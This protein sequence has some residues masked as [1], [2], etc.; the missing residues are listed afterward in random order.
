MTNDFSPQHITSIFFSVSL[1][2]S[3]FKNPKVV[4]NPAHMERPNMKLSPKYPTSKE[5]E[6]L[7]LKEAQTKSSLRPKTASFC[8]PVALPVTAS[9]ALATHGSHAEPFTGSSSYSPTKCL[10]AQ[11]NDWGS[12]RGTYLPH[13]EGL[14]CK[15]RQDDCRLH[16]S[17]PLATRPPSPASGTWAC[18]DRPGACAGSAPPSVR[19]GRSAARPSHGPRGRWCGAGSRSAATR[20]CWGPPSRRTRTPALH[21]EWTGRG[22]P[23]GM[24]NALG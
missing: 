6:A 1:G 3:N 21:R 16:D 20:A 14:G 5:K 13:K 17:N 19:W 11:L 15:P 23:P 9:S 8:T 24:G 12:W 7:N 2:W 10:I 18:R 22:S 4:K